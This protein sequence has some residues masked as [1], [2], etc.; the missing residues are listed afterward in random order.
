MGLTGSLTFS[1]SKSDSGTKLEVT[2]AV[3]GYAPGRLNN[4]A[5]PVDNVIYEQV[6]R[7][8]NFIEKGSLE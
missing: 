2:Y 1:L 8:K 4:F 5:A 3:G 6:T 7:L